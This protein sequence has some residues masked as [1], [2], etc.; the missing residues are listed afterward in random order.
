PAAGGAVC[1]VH[2]GGVPVRSSV[3]GHRPAVRADP[4]LGPRPGLSGR[5]KGPRT[6]HPSYG[7]MEPPPAVC[8]GRGLLQ[9]YPVAKGSALFAGVATGV[10]Y[11]ALLLLLGLFIDLTVNRGDIPAYQHLWPQEQAAFAEE[12]KDPL[13]RLRFAGSGTWEQNLPQGGGGL[14]DKDW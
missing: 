1:P 6:P 11:V 4:L 5:G 3:H 8:R 14:S 2:I 7:V 12:W 13:K 9:H 10:L